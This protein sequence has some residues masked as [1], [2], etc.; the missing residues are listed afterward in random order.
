MRDSPEH[1]A[2]ALGGRCRW[3]VGCRH[4][5]CPDAGLKQAGWNREI[6]GLPN[7]CRA[8]LLEPCSPTTTPETCSTHPA[9]CLDTKFST[10]DH[11]GKD[12]STFAETWE[13]EL[14]DSSAGGRPV[15]A[16]RCSREIL[17]EQQRL[18]GLSTLLEQPWQS[19]L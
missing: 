18:I 9:P 10:A 11:T 4:K 14:E 3:H 16:A 17:H 5:G 7:V 6:P 19:R 12:N 1:T 8:M 13:L 15:R 2:L